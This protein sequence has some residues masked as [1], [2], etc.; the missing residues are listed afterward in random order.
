MAGK[1]SE[2]AGEIF[3][4]IVKDLASDGR[5]IVKHPH[6]RTYFVPGV[7][8]NEKVV[9]KIKGI[10]GKTGFAEC[11][12]ILLASPSRINAKCQHHG[13]S[14]G[15]C[16][17]CP[18]QFIDYTAQLDA[19]QKRVEKVFSRL[20]LQDKVKTIAGSSNIFSYRNRAQFKTDG[21][22]IGYVS[23][24][25]NTLVPIQHCEVLSDYNKHTLQELIEQLPNKNWQPRGKQ[26]WITLDIDHDVSAQNISVN[27]RLPF[28]QANDGQNQYMRNWLANKLSVLDKGCHVLELFCGSGNFTEVISEQNFECIYAADAAGQA[29]ESLFLRELRGVRT[30]T[31]DLFKESEFAKILNKAK[32]SEVLVLDPPRDG[33]KVK[34]DIFAK[35]SKLK[36]IFYISCDLATLSRDIEAFVSHRY[37][38]LEIQPLDQFPHTPHIE[39]LVH[40]RK[41]DNH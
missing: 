31:A 11:T 37:K 33:L 36:H 3:E 6:G 28:K 24:Q 19:K 41:K 17:A 10:K 26:P 29:I 25:S 9:V 34:G 8:L 20:N 30:M 40:L 4:A 13:V 27:K 12:E 22:H 16:G 21:I 7:W 23:S 32:Q 1:E 14:L 5:G 2:K 35:K 38:V 15:K 18:W 39:C